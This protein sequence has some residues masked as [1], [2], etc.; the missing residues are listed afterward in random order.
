MEYSAQDLC[1]CTA[2]TSSSSA[3][4]EGLS[5]IISCSGFDSARD[6]GDDDGEPLL[7]SDLF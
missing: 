7:P 6:D 5:G 2:S 1:G 3:Q 4:H